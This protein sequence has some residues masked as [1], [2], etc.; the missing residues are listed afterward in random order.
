MDNKQK[1]IDALEAERKLFN[2]RGQL[3]TNHDAALFYLKNGTLPTGV[4]A[5]DYDLLD[6]AVNDFDCLCSDYG[7]K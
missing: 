2:G 1:L 6:A 5:E 7:I 3:T 4:K